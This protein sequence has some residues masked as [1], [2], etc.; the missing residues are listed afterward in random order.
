[1]FRLPDG[2]IYTICAEYDLKGNIESCKRTEKNTRFIYSTSKKFG[3]SAKVSWLSVPLIVRKEIWLYITRQQENNPYDT[4]EANFLYYGESEDYIW[5]ATHCVYSIEITLMLIQKIGRFNRYRFIGSNY[6][7][8]SEMPD[9][10]QFLIDEEKLIIIRK[11][12]RKPTF[13]IRSWKTFLVQERKREQWIKEVA[14][15]A[16]VPIEIAK[17][18]SPKIRDKEKAIEILKTIRKRRPEF[19]KAIKDNH[20]VYVLYDEWLK[21]LGP[22]LFN[23]LNLNNATSPQKLIDY[24]MK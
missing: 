7:F 12:K 22:E 24:L 8:A 1:M 18:L 6:R 23:E 2:E 14:K 5:A 19:N 10:I 21:I 9:D 4:E 3:D 15:K 11:G 20:L 16:V 13:I 17:L